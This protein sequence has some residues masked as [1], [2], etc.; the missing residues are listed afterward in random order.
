MPRRRPAAGG[1][2]VGPGVARERAHAH[3]GQGERPGHDSR[4]CHVSVPAAEE[5]VWAPL[6]VRFPR[7]QGGLLCRCGWGRGELI[8]IEGDRE[9]EF[10][11]IADRL[12]IRGPDGSSRSHP[13]KDFLRPGPLQRQNIPSSTRSREQAHRH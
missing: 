8:A 1:W 5:H 9:G 13:F 12:T 11:G 6:E 4:A 2:H 10:V 7:M 3:A